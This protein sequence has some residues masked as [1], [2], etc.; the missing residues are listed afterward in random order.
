M[1]ANLCKYILYK[2]GYNSLSIT[3]FSFLQRFN[4]P[5]YLVTRSKLTTGPLSGCKFNVSMPC[6]FF[7]RFPKQSINSLEQLLLLISCSKN[8]VINHYL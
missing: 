7:N 4:I 8:F 6:L 3:L 5:T 2:K 1:C